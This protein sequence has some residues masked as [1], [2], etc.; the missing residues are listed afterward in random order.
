MGCDIHCFV[1]K[2]N[3]KSGKWEKISGFENAEGEK[4]CESPFEN[5]DYSEFAILANVRNGWGISPD[6]SRIKPIAMPKGVP[7]DVSPKVKEKID[8]W[9][10]DGHSH[11]YLTAKEIS[12]YDTNNAINIRGYVN[13]REY[14]KFKETGDVDAFLVEDVCGGNTIKK[15]ND[16]CIDFQEKNPDK[17]VFTQIEFKRTAAELA[18]WL[19]GDGLKQLM[20]RSEDGTGDDVRI[21]FFFDN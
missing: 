16:E 4:P 11:S 2:K 15:P 5:R 10:D 21:V 7:E 1:E 13:V 18:R 19:F 20:E 17:C 6:R 3:R 8:D 9:A 14:K 12:E